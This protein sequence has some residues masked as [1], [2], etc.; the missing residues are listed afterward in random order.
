MQYT[1]GYPFGSWDAEG[2]VDRD[3]EQFRI[4]DPKGSWLIDHQ[5]ARPYSGDT[6][7]TVPRA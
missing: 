5:N 1:T 2:P 6:P 7:D 4:F 3:Y